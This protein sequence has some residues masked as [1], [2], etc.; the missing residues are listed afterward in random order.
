[1]NETK[2]AEGKKRGC[3]YVV[4]GSQMEPSSVL[5]RILDRKY[6]A[7]KI[8]AGDTVVFSSR[9]IPGYE[10]AVHQAIGQIIWSGAQAIFHGH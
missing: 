4:S 3:I 8:E 1:M 6:G 5:K 9:T 2:I 10:R 7:L